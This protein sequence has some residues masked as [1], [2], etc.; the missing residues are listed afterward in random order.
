MRQNEGTFETLYHQFY[1]PVMRYALRRVGPAHAADVV[2][3][4]FLVAWRKP[5]DVP[6]GDALV[7]LYAVAFNLIRNQRRSQ[8]KWILSVDFRGD[9]GGVAAD[10][11][12]HDDADDVA[13]RVD[14]RKAMNQLDFDDAEVLRLVAWEGLSAGEAAGVL[15][16]TRATFRVRLHRAR[17][18]LGRLLA[19]SPEFE[20]PNPL[21]QGK[22]SA[23]E[24]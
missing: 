8:R 3:E 21:F 2:A 4:T 7:W 16:C 24:I 22:L 1:E 18:R 23:D 11:A 15:G 19:D 17:S 6:S 9:Q 12:V 14:L 13:A 5:A 10:V 20:S